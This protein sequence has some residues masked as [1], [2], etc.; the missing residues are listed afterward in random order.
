[1]AK[2]MT[3]VALLR[4]INVGGN[5]KVEMP[6]LKQAFERLGLKEVSTYINSGNVIFKTDKNP[7]QLVPVIEQ[8]IE[9]DFGLQVPVVIRS[10]PQIQ[11]IN[12]ALPKSW[13][14]NKEVRTDV[15]FLWEDVASPDVLDQLT[16][17]S[18]IDKVKYID[19]TVIW[20]VTRQNQTKSGLLK[21]MGT[22]LYKRMSIRNSNTLRKLCELMEITNG[23]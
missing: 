5:S 2:M 21:I 3:Y 1:M 11:A 22:S 17:R 9:R 6:K 8:K 19:G 15:M 4:G 7:H 20:H 16:I 14:T 18:E 10:L 23:N 13:L 12:K